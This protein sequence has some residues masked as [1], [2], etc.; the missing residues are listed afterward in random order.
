MNALLLICA[1]VA[2]SN[3]IIQKMDG[4]YN[5]WHVARERDAMAWLKKHQPESIVIDLDLLGQS[6]NLILDQ[7]KEKTSDSYTLTIG[8]CKSPEPLPTLLL[9]RFD[10]LIVHHAI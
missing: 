1:D 7:V 5:I 8:I 2:L 6:A 9:D 3:N 10:Q 4:D